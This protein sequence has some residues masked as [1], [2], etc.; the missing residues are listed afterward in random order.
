M[1]WLKVSSFARSAQVAGGEAQTAEDGQLLGGQFA[2]ENLA[3]VGA[4]GVLL[5]CEQFVAD[6]AAGQLAAV[7]QLG[8]ASR[9]QVDIADHRDIGHPPRGQQQLDLMELPHVV[10]QLRNDPAAPARI[11]RRSL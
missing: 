8:H 1:I 2:K 7:E 9:E 5:H 11:F 4:G 10:S 6:H 3:L